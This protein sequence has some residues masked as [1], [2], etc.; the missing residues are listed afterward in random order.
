MYLKSRNLIK[1]IFSAWLYDTGNS[2]AFLIP[3]KLHLLDFRGAHHRTSLSQTDQEPISGNYNS[4]Y[5]NTKLYIY[6][7]IYTYIYIYSR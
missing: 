3:I 4:F 1:V 2:S 5:I 7:F 6:I